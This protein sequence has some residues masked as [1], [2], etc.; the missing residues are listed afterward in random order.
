VIVSKRSFR[1]GDVVVARWLIRHPSFLVKIVESR[2]VCSEDL[3][4]ENVRLWSVVP[5]WPCVGIPVRGHGLMRSR[6]ATVEMRRGYLGYVPRGGDFRARTE[7]ADA[8]GVFL[9]W[10]PSV[11]GPSWGPEL[12]RVPIGAGDLARVERALAL[13]VGGAAALEAPVAELFAIFS[14]FGALYSRDLAAIALPPSPRVVRAGD[15]I[16]QVMSQVGSRPRI[17][18]LMQALDCSE[19]QA[20]Y[21]VAE[22]AGA[23]ALQG[24]TEWRTLVNVWTTYLAGLLMTADGATTRGV[25]S[26]LGYG[27]A[28]AFCHAL[29]NSGLP[30]PGE[31]RRVV[32]ELGRT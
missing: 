28:N 25:A 7:R 13:I 11:F 20:R 21:L 22:Y 29:T 19:R 18:D 15:A 3:L 4:W 16:D 10:D 26:R 6:D 31:L 12:S 30:P 1:C 8:F 23:Y 32:S 14:S 27:S 24:V 2:G 9:Q 5:E 17:I